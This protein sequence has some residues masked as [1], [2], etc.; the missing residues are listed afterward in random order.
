M[1][2]SS[3]AQPVAKQPVA[4]PV[5]EQPVAPPADAETGYAHRSRGGRLGLATVGMIAAL[6][7]AWG[8]ILPFVGP[9]FSYS[10]DGSGS[11]HWSLSHSF[12]ALVPGV[13]GVL[14]GLFVMARSRVV[15]VGRGRLTLSTAGM[16]LVLCGAWFALGPWVWPVVSS[17]GH[18]FAAGSPLSLLEHVVGYSIGTG[19]IIVACG[20]YAIG[21]ASRFD[22]R[23]LPGPAMT[24]PMLRHDAPVAR[25]E[26]PAV[27]TGDAP[28]VRR[29]ETEVESGATL[30]AQERAAGGTEGPAEG[31]EEL[32]RDM[33]AETDA[34]VFT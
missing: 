17:S 24:G 9:M 33:P 18:Y 22:R 16:I 11:W 14:L 12:L 1:T 26:A 19:V 6:V 32:G 13:V 10:A 31:G 30:G 5:A 7:S 27:R 29:D 23:A 20:G 34:P 8:G 3:V 21:W 15:D 28:L 2:T 4:H 25:R